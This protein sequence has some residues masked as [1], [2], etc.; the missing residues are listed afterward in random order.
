MTIVDEQSLFNREYPE[1]AINIKMRQI[2]LI[3]EISICFITYYI[4]V[5]KC[6][7]QNLTE[8]LQTY[9]HYSCLN[10]SHIFYSS[11]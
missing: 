6:L 11:Q 8:I 4:F 3:A 5:R 9:K 1:I 10:I 7:R 2:N